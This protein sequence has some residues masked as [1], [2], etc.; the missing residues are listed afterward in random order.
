MK[1]ITN[2]PDTENKALMPPS[3]FIAHGAPL[4][5]K[6]RDWTPPIILPFQIKEKTSLVDAIASMANLKC[7]CWRFPTYFVRNYK[8]CELIGQLYCIFLMRPP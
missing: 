8:V 5:R 2:A 6:A 4:I 3:W 7:R 1:C